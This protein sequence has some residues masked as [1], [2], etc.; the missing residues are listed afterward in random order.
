M[1]KP[2]ESGE[3]C[4]KNC[5]CLHHQGLYCTGHQTSVKNIEYTS[6]ILVGKLAKS[7]SFEDQEED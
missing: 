7:D 5:L 2:C 1:I 3:D 6:I 4:F